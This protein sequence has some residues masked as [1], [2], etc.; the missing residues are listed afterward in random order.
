MDLADR[1]VCT[2]CGACMQAC[3]KQAIRMEEDREG[4]PTPAISQELCVE[5]GLCQ[6][7][8]PAIQMPQTQPVSAA[9]A[10]QILDNIKALD[11][12]SFSEEELRLIDE[13]SI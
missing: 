1:S 5:C 8:C 13:I 12:C 11:N 9:Y 2:G 6:K 10:A 3:P 4:F 7:V